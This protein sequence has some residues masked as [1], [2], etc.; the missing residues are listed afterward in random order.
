MTANIPI[1]RHEE[2][3]LSRLRDY[4]ILDTSPEEAFDRITRL[5]A[6]VLDAPI[7][8]VSLVDENRQ[9]FKSRQGLDASETPRELA[10]CAHAIAQPDL[11]VV[12]DATKDDRFKDNP[13][14]TAAPAIRFYAGAQLWTADGLG[15]GT[16]CVI[17]T[18]PVQPTVQQLADLEDLAALAMDA[19]NLRRA[20]QL[21][22]DQA[23]QSIL[24][25]DL[26]AA[27]IDNI[28]HEF[29]QPLTSLEGSLSLLSSGALGDLPSETKDFVDIAE[30][31]AKRLL[32][33]WADLRDMSA[34]DNGALKLELEQTDMTAL[35]REVVDEIREHVETDAQRITVE[36][37]DT[38][39]DV[40]GDRAKLKYA[41]RHIITNALQFSTM[42]EPVFVRVIGGLESLMIQVIDRGPGIPLR[43]RT[44][45]FGKFVKLQTLN[46]DPGLGLGL[47]IAKGVIEAHGG[48]LSIQTNPSKG[49]TVSIELPRSELA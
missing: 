21:A 26:K 28:N 3:R 43:D 35:V 6:H 2:S 30:R 16:L 31:G 19:L 14:V 27:F 25:S 12:P 23:K 41:I 1:P 45:I 24:I 44:R 15:L 18:K 48:L 13:L 20:G 46:R 17:D 36:T 8:L 9:W 34:I 10:F 4:A 32:D 37:R 38:K 47:S 42:E 39:Q 11:L 5:A 7:A 22:L 33:L 49:I 40:I 29:G